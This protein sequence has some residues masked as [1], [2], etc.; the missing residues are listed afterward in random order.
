M[1]THEESSRASLLTL[2]LA[3]AVIAVSAAASPAFAGFWSFLGIESESN[4]F[5]M[6]HVR[7]LAKM[8]GDTEHK[9]YVFDVNPDDLREKEGIIPGSILLSSK[10]DYE[11]ALLPAD[12]NSPLVFYCANYL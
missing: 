3:C 2:A 7:D 1:M 4:N 12:K 8:F 6:I 5:Q 10:R 11:L 9:V